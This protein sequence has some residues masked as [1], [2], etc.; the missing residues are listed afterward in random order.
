VIDLVLRAL[1]P[2][3]MAALFTLIAIC[4]F[5]EFRSRPLTHKEN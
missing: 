3:A 4:A 2:A 1:F 5:C